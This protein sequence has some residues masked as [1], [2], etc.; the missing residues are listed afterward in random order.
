MALFDI[1]CKRKA[2]A[3]FVDGP[4]MIRKD[5]KVDLAEVKREASKYGDVA[6]ANVYLDQYAPKKLIE[7]VINQG[8]SP[9]IATG[10]IDVAMAVDSVFFASTRKDITTI[11]FVTRDTDFVP[12]I[13]R[14]KELGGKKIVVIAT[15]KGVSS[16]LKHYCDDI[17]I[18]D[19]STGVRV[20]PKK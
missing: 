1:F 8:F 3:I 10:D 19:S 17:I 2:V 14:I 5:S 15:S 16:A 18:F 9:V 7:A 12:A 11:I 20:T 6:I 13:S 4:N